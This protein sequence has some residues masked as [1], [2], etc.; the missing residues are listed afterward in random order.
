MKY[1]KITLMIL[2]VLIGAGAL[3]GTTPHHPC[4]APIIFGR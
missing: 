2:S 4:R 3:V 1:F